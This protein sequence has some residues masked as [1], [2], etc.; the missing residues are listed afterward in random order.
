[1]AIP[2]AKQLKTGFT[3]YVKAIRLIRANKLTRYLL[4]PAILNII[5]IIAFIFSGVGVGDWINGIIERST[6][7]MNGWIHAGMVA[8][9]IILPIVFFSRRKQANNLIRRHHAE[10]VHNLRV[11]GERRLHKLF[12]VTVFLIDALPCKKVALLVKADSTDACINGLLKNIVISLAELDHRCQ[13]RPHPQILATH[14]G[15]LLQLVIFFLF[16]ADKLQL[17]LATHI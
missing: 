14:L 8:I 11:E 12:R 16:P 13:K 3:A 6:E 7:N 10:E 4:I 5:V 1:M 17:D 9:K 2:R 15:F